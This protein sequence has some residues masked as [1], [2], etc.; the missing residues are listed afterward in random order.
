MFVG[1]F[2]PI[3]LSFYLRISTTVAYESMTVMISF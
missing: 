1:C 3:V 2:I